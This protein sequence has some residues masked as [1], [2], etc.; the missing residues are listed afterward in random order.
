[1]PEANSSWTLS[2][3]ADEDSLSEFVAWIKEFT[4]ANGDVTI[5]ASLDT[6]DRTLF[7]IAR[8]TPSDEMDDEPDLDDLGFEFVD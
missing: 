5:D 3:P 8:G 6:E 7:L 2:F 4:D 1:M